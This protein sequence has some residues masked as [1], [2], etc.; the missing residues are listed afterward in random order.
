MALKY[1]LRNFVQAKKYVLT[2]V[3]VSQDNKIEYKKVSTL[4]PP[5]FYWKSRSQDCRQDNESSQQE[6]SELKNWWRN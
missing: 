1:T 5:K 4:R 3:T 6:L 2:K